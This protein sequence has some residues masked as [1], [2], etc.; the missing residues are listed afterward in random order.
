M[1]VPAFI[2][3]QQD[4]VLLRLKVQPRSSRNE[5]GQPLGN[6]LRVKV[7][8]PP[9]DAAANEAVIKLLAETLDWPRNKIH[10]VRGHT[11]LH[12]EIKVYGIALEG[13]L[14]KLSVA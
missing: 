13:L 14:S 5:I 4:C 8:A 12:K 7:T 3:V 10:L 11:S 9:V 6:Q 1:I 2:H